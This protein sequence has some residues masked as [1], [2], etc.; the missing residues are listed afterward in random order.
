MDHQYSLLSVEERCSA[1]GITQDDLWPLYRHVCSAEMLYEP[2]PGDWAAIHRQVCDRLGREQ[3]LRNSG[4]GQ[5]VIMFYPKLGLYPALRRSKE[6]T[7]AEV[8]LEKRRLFMYPGPHF[9]E[10]FAHVQQLGRAIH[11]AD[12]TQERSGD[13]SDK[14]A[15][16]KGLGAL[17]ELFPGPEG[18]PTANGGEA[19]N[20]KMLS[21]K[22]HQVYFGKFSVYLER[23]RT[24]DFLR[25]GL[26]S[27]L[28]DFDET[29]G[30]R[31]L[32][33][34][35]LRELRGTHPGPTYSGLI[36]RMHSPER[37]QIK[38]G[39]WHD[40]GLNDSVNVGPG[41]SG[42]TPNLFLDEN[43]TD[44][45]GAY[46]F[47]LHQR[48]LN[49]SA[50]GMRYL[51][52]CELIPV[53]KAI[54]GDILPEVIPEVLYVSM[55]SYALCSQSGFLS[56]SLLP[57]QLDFDA[58]DGQLAI[59]RAVMLASCDPRRLARRFFHITQ[60]RFVHL[61]NMLDRGVIADQV[62]HHA[63]RLLGLVRATHGSLLH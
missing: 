16:S 22:G 13:I 33:A 63:P 10:L 49:N 43:E 51:L 59:Q 18:E 9:E 35:T 41:P 19:D 62:Y 5:A 6:S 47:T 37:I 28:L 57:N 36:E 46:L 30:K 8:V 38:G 1:L 25:N 20:S 26:Y 3:V 34:K 15:M 40:P 55:V 11:A 50:S 42:W 53:Q 32:S 45:F 48:L 58:E 2:L 14:V 31:T 56:N 54:D 29:V 12:K 23:P 39:K 7:P 61:P 44:G 17:R 52:A 24:K 4:I 27:H 60:L 21:A